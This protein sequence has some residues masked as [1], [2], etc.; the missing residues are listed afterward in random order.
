MLEINSVRKAYAE[1]IAVKDLSLTVHQGEIYGVLG[2]NGAGKTSTIRMICGITIPDKGS[3]TFRGEPISER[4]QAKIGYL[5]EERGL[6]KKMKVADILIYLAELKGLSATD[7][8]S[9]SAHWMKRFEIESWATKKIQELSKGMQ[10]KVQFISVV[11]HEPELLILDEPFSGLDP[12]NSELIMDVILELKRAGKTILFSTHRMEQVEKICDS[13]CLINNGEKVLDGNVRDVKR[14]YGKNTIHLDF[15][16]SDAFITA[17]ESSGLISLSD[18][19]PKSV[20]LK[21]LNGTST[22]DIL[23]KIPTDVEVTR[24]ELAEPSLKDIFI[25]RVGETTVKP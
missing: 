8:K 13:I 18:R 12:I 10:Q 24:F 14:G 7:A 5:P 6:Y 22:R 15:E 11:L 25:M 9:R 17:L 19:S 23:A 1:K 20:E 2:P 21:L 3:I 16:G 4:V